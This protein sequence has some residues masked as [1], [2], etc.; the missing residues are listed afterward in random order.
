MQRLIDTQNHI[1]LKSFQNN[2]SRKSRSL[3]KIEEILVSVRNIQ[4]FKGQ[5]ILINYSDI[6]K[7]RIETEIRVHSL[8][9]KDLGEK[10]MSFIERIGDLLKCQLKQKKEQTVLVQVNLVPLDW[11]VNQDGSKDN[12]KLLSL[13][14]LLES[15]DDEELY[16]TH[17]VDSLKAAAIMLKKTAFNLGFLPFTVQMIVSVLYFSFFVLSEEQEISLINRFFWVMVAITTLYFLYIEYRQ[18]IG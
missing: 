12:H 14:P 16:T 9:N 3:T 17:F 1:I 15:I 8:K 5:D 2:W 18:L 11:I 6:T 4:D 13:I 10:F 7:E